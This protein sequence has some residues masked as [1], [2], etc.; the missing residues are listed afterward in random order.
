M[1]EWKTLAQ[2][3]KDLDHVDATLDNMAAGRT[4]VYRSEPGTPCPDCGGAYYDVY[5]SY[6]PHLDSMCPAIS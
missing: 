3:R 6:I 4:M 2:I 5:G 1:S